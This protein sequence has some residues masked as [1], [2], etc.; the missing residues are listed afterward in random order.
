MNG[1][2]GPRWLPRGTAELNLLEND[3]P[4]FTT[5]NL[6]I[7]YEDI[8]ERILNLNPNIRLSKKS[9]RYFR[10]LVFASA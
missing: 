2:T 10:K 1:R 5:W 8:H 6:F 9:K 3:E 7:K 4:I